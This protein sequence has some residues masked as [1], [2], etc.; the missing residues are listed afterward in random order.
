MT[1]NGLGGTCNEKLWGRNVDSIAQAT[2][3]DIMDKRS[4]VGD[5]RVIQAHY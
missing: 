5:S 2:T 1:G 4:D 3:K